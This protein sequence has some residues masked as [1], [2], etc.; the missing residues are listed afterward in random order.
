M[1]SGTSWMDVFLFI[2][3]LIQLINCTWQVKWYNIIGGRMSLIIPLSPKSPKKDWQ[4]GDIKVPKMQNNRYF[5]I[6]IT[7]INNL[8]QILF[9]MTKA[10]GAV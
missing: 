10:K 3:L 2:T 6:I 5:K 1:N 7:L 9:I 4:K 8:N